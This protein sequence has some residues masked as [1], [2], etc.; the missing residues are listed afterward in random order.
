M[1]TDDEETC[2]KCGSP[3]RTLRAGG[4]R[5]RGCLFCLL[6]EVSPAPGTMTGLPIESAEAFFADDSDSSSLHDPGVYAL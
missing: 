1:A 4:N 6:V 2:A 5:Y 3:L